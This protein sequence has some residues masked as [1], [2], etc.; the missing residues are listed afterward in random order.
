MRNSALLLA[1]TLAVTAT[2]WAGPLG[3]SVTARDPVALEGPPQDPLFLPTD[4]AVGPDGMVWVADGVKGRVAC[5]S[6]DGRWTEPVRNVGEHALVTP[7]GLDVDAQGRLWIA[8]TGLAKVLVRAPDGSL[9][10]VLALPGDQGPIN[11]TDVVVTNDGKRALVVDNDAHRIFVLDEGAEQIEIWGEKG[12][13]LGQLDHPFMITADDKGNAWVTDVLN[14]RVKSLSKRLEARNAVGS[15]GVELG[16]LYR[17]KGIDLDAEEHLWV[18]DGDLGVVQVYN[19]SGSL[20]DVLRDASGAVLHLEAP[21]GVA[22]VADQLYVVEATRNRVLRMTVT[23][24]PGRRQP[25]E[26]RPVLE[27]KPKDCT[28]CHMELMPMLA[29]GLPTEIARVPPAHVDQPPA[30]R[31]QACFSCHDGSVEDS[32]KPVWLEHGHGSDVPIPEGMRVD[33]AIP[34]V[35]G[36]IACRSCHTAHSQGGSGRSC[37]EAVFLRVGEQPMELCLAC[38]GDMNEQRSPVPREHGDDDVPR[39]SGH[40]VD[41]EP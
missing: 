19:T 32:R 41:P 35:E 38:H 8:D 12:E 37:A 27:G 7:M 25:P 33:A 13:S 11:P 20:V 10:R 39:P 36:R 24:E 15:Y 34:L 21:S 2:A 18:S 6:P 26:R 22:R 9:E 17:P 5:F 31:E 1:A 23:V 30:S 3:P 28:A 14:G 4:V 40:L 29:Q 16:E